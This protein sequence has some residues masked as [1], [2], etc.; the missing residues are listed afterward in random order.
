MR[1]FD[2][3]AIEEEYLRALFD[4]LIAFT[5]K[6]TVTSTLTNKTN[7]DSIKCIGCKNDFYIY[8]LINGDIWFSFRTEDLFSDKWRNGDIWFLLHLLDFL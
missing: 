1:T 2:V 4:F 3:V 7:R 5:T 8:S 6:Y